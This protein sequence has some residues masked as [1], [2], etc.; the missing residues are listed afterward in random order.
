MARVKCH[1]L[2]L[3]MSVGACG[4]G[5]PEPAAV[6]PSTEEAVTKCEPKP[7][8]AATAKATP[9]VLVCDDKG[10]LTAATDACNGGDAA[11]CYVVGSCFAMQIL[12]I[13]DKDPAQRAKAVVLVKNALRIACDG[14]I[15]DGC[16]NRAGMIENQETNR[17]AREEACEDII[18][19]CQLGKQAGCV[20]CFA[21]GG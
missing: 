10:E 20:G 21:C 5:T 8:L 6:E 4:G 12:M 13:G 3:V 15:A 19:A 11:Q 14:G 7:A 17:Q 2:V 16:Y 1:L 9:K 18:R